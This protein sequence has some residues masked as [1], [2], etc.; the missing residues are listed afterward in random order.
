[1]ITNGSLRSRCTFSRSKVVT[2]LTALIDG[3]RLR[4]GDGQ[5]QKDWRDSF[6]V[7]RE[8]LQ[9]AASLFRCTVVVLVVVN[10][11]TE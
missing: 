4:L 8:L 11:D 3:E 7:R 1:M 2:K 10:P 9:D 6:V 5:V